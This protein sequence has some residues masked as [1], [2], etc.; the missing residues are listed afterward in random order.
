MVRKTRSRRV[1]RAEDRETISVE[2]YP[3]R[4]AK[5]RQTDIQRM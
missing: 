3:P 4:C 1:E 2:R 5:S